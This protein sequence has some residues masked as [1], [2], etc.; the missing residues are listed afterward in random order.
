MSVGR[1]LTARH[2]CAGLVRWRYDDPYREPVT[3]ASKDA[4]GTIVARRR[5]AN[6]LVVRDLAQDE[7]M[8]IG[9][10]RRIDLTAQTWHALEALTLETG[11]PANDLAEEAFCDLFEKHR[12]P[13]SLREA[14]REAAPPFHADEP[15]PRKRA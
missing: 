12:R 9:M 8:E 5:S 1:T 2:D 6:H 3:P 15:L 4:R 13:R 11:R 14:L 10:T 7:A